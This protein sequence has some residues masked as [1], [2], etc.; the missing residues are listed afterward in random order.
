MMTVQ[1]RFKEAKWQDSFGCT[2]GP[3]DYTCVTCGV[4]IN[5]DAGRAI[6]HSW[7]AGLEC[8]LET[9]VKGNQQ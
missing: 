4:K 3:S 9:L 7:H 1:D 2:L 5:D 6:H 8:D